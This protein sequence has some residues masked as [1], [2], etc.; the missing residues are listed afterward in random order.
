MIWWVPFWH[1]APM[2]IPVYPNQQD[3]SASIIVCEVFSHITFCSWP[4]ISIY[5]SKR[6]DSGSRKVMRFT[7]RLCNKQT[8]EPAQ[9]TSLSSVLFLALKSN[10]DYPHLEDLLA[11]GS[12]RATNRV[13]EP[14]GRGCIE[15]FAF[16]QIPRWCQCCWSGDRW[17]TARRCHEPRP[18]LFAYPSLQTQKGFIQWNSVW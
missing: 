13:P 7:S 9:E 3:S 4:V 2:P 18:T 17:R 16:K 12:L 5:L 8:V 15:A 6:G 11:H 14:A 10:G 1:T